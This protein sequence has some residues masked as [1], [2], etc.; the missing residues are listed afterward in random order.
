MVQ[1]KNSDAQLQKH[2]ERRSRRIPEDQTTKTVQS[3]RQIVE[4]KS[5]EDRILHTD[6]PGQTIKRVTQSRRSLLRRRI[7]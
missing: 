1:G 7:G 4:E 6:S 3:E 2:V 5:L